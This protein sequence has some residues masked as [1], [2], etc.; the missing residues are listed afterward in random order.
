MRS[1]GTQ[2]IGA[3]GN[4]APQTPPARRVGLLIDGIS[5]A[6]RTLFNTW[7]GAT[8]GIINLVLPVADSW[9]T[10]ATVDAPFWG[11][12]YAAQAG[13]WLWSLPG[14]LSTDNAVAFEAAAAGNS[15]ANYLTM[16]KAIL[17]ASP[18]DGSVIYIRPDWEH[19]YAAGTHP[20]CWGGLA[21]GLNWSIAEYRQIVRCGRAISNRFRFVWCM[22]LNDAAANPL[23]NPFLAYPGDAYVD[24]IDIDTYWMHSQGG[25]TGFS[26]G[27]AAWSQFTT[28]PY[29]IT[30]VIR[31][32]VGHGKKVGIS[33]LGVDFNLA[34]FYSSLATLMATAPFE[35]ICLYDL[36]DGTFNTRLSDQDY[37]LWDVGDDFVTSFG[38][39]HRG[40]RKN[41]TADPTVVDGTWFTSANATWSG[42]R[43]TNGASATNFEWRAYNGVAALAAG[44]YEL[45]FAYNLVAASTKGF[46][47]LFCGGSGQ[48]EYL[49][50]DGATVWAGGGGKSAN[51]GTPVFTTTLSAKLVTIPVTV[52][53]G[54]TSFILGAGPGTTTLGNALDVYGARLRSIV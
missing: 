15:N 4:P 34:G 3:L 25:L 30:D 27:A 28:M 19:N 53:S 42:N 16:F 35:Y 23:Y 54:A 14:L 47:S 32:A 5:D 24:I 38:V 9:S 39:S 50:I 13:P 12:T 17:A 36:N 44:S 18:N 8:A 45:Q 40:A 33:E 7:L 46:F 41:T 48:N 43:I 21:G 10:K 52:N 22:A 29:G 20:W 49:Y 51:F 1:A 37:K 2:L 6:Q 11:T 26:T 31:F